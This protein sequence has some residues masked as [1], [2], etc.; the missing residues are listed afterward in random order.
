M[1]GTH[2]HTETLY[3]GVPQ[4]LSSGAGRAGRHSEGK[5]EAG[6]LDGHEGAQET[7]PSF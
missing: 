3:L 2:T 4:F 1:A 6:M 5:E 7:R